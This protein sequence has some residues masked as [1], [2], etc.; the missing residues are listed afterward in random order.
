MPEIYHFIC[1]I[2]R[3]NLQIAFETYS[4]DN[5]RRCQKERFNAIF[6]FF[7]RCLILDSHMTSHPTKHRKS[8][9]LVDMHAD[10]MLKALNVDTTFIQVTRS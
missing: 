4:T 5:M 2:S 9:K 3:P 10:G 8:A 6:P 1:D 7:G